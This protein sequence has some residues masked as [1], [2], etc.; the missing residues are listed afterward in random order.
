MM[1]RVG[2]VWVLLLL[3]FVEMSGGGG[4]VSWFEEVM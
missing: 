1:I 2:E 4:M 3:L